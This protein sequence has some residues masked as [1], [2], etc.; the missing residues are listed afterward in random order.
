MRGLYD[1]GRF[2][3]S[4]NYFEWAI[5][6]KAFGVDTVVFD[7][8]A[9]KTTK[10]PRDIVIRRFGSILMPGPALSG[11]ACEVV[12]TQQTMDALC[13]YI[14]DMST[15]G[16]S[17]TVRVVEEAAKRRDIPD[18]AM[19]A[20]PG[21]Q[22]LVQHV[23]RAAGHIHRLR[24]VLPPSTARYTVTLRNTQRAEGRNSDGAMWRAFARDIGAVVIPDYDDVPIHL[25]DR[26]ALYASAEMNYFCSNGPGILCSLTDYPCVMFNTHHASGSLRREGIGWG[27]PYPWMC[28]GRQFSVWEEATG[29]TLR[30]WHAEHVTSRRVA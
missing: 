28:P 14:D 3:T 10:W 5:Q 16:V 17:V 9:I 6:A 1:C 27:E 19:V 24:S 7:A 20:E 12:T 29:E 30:A 25:Y 4:F 18:V 15:R 26:M 8:R 23:R 21:G 2:L 11:M 22:A 13:Q